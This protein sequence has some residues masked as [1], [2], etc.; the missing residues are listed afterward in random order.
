MIIRMN[1]LSPPKE[2]QKTIQVLP[3]NILDNTRMTVTRDNRQQNSS[4]KKIRAQQ[5]RKEILN[6]TSI[7]QVSESSE[8]SGE[9]DGN[10]GMKDVDAFISMIKEHKLSQQEF[11]Y[12]IKSKKH[13]NDAYNMRIVNYPYIQKH[14]FNNFYTFSAKII[15]FTIEYRL[16]QSNQIIK[17]FQEVSQMEDFKEMAKNITFTQNFYYLSLT[18]QKVVEFKSNLLKI[19]SFTQKSMFYIQHLKLQMQIKQKIY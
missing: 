1:P 14:Y 3:S 7:S 6:K 8:E 19:K 10:F 15:I 16:I 17:F 12:L 4:K 18:L 9:E 13:S 2:V 5:L 11:M